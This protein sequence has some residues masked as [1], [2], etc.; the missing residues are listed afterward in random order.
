MVRAL[1]LHLL[2]KRR[3]IPVSTLRKFHRGRP[4]NQRRVVT[5]GDAKAPTLQL[6]QISTIWITAWA[7]GDPRRL[8]RCST[9][10]LLTLVSCRL[11]RIHNH[12]RWKLLDDPGAEWGGTD[13]RYILSNTFCFFTVV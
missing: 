1:L 12:R 9:F 8:P 4:I 6:R 3:T 7:A 11:C 5:K 13:I 2:W 10:L